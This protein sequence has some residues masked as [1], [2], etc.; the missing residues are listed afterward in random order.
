MTLQVNNQLG[1]YYGVQ[2]DHLAEGADP[3]QPERHAARSTAS[4][5]CSTSHGSKLAIVAWR[6]GGAVYWISNTLTQN[7][8]NSQM[9]AIAASLTRA[10]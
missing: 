4:T 9:L 1:Q 5:W 3:R 8:S 7:L 10:K 2:G 6:T